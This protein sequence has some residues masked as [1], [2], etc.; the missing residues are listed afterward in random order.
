[1]TKE[2]RDKA[3]HSKF[4]V[5][6]KYE[7]KSWPIGWASKEGQRVERLYYASKDGVILAV[8]SSWEDLL[9]NER[10]INF[11]ANKSA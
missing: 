1:M 10:P 8:G 6:V 11:P 2:E 3:L 5:G 4:G 9:V 7:S